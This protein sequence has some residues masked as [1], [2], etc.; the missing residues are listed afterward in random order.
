MST[1]GRLCVAVGESVPQGVAIHAALDADAC[2]CVC[3]RVCVPACVCRR[4]VATVGG[5]S[6]NI[7]SGG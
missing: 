2:V 5:G 6:H 3:L 1:E 7:A 4:S